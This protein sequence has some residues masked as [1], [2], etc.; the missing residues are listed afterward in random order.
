MK[1]SIR[2]IWLLLALLC[3]ASAQQPAQ[4]FAWDVK[5]APD[6]TARSNLTVENFCKKKHSFRITLENITFMRFRETEVTVAGRKTYDVP[7]VFDTARMIPGVNLGKVI[8]TCLTC[9]S[10]ATCTQDREVLAVRLEVT[11]SPGQLVTATAQPVTPPR[12]TDGPTEKPPC[13]QDLCEEARGRAW[14][15]EDGATAAEMLAEE[16]R[17]QADT[18]EQ[19]A[20]AAEDTGRQAATSVKDGGPGIVD[21][22]RKRSYTGNAFEALGLATRQ[23]FADLRDR[24]ITTA[25]AQQKTEQLVGL[26][27]LDSVQSV[28]S[29]NQAQ[30]RYTANQAAENAKQARAAANGAQETA[31][32]AQTAAKKSRED[33][34]QAR[35]KFEDCVGKVA[36]GCQGL[37]R[38]QQTATT[39]PQERLETINILFNTSTSLNT[40]T[41]TNPCEQLKI[42]CDKLRFEVANLE[43]QLTQAQAVLE[44]ARKRANNLEAEAQKAEESARRAAEADASLM[45]AAGAFT[46]KAISRRVAPQCARFGR[47]TA[48]AKSPPSRRN[49]WPRS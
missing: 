45:K 41:P 12:T 8:V 6:T 33:A 34:Q 5:L 36:A 20:R 27:G 11:G 35:N 39:Q 23:V 7:V 1:S 18:F 9:G 13:S 2:S 17:A 14:H 10:E 44:A 47:I 19:A 3:T 15:Q 26:D 40:S 21:E 38:D 24:K 48:Q 42:D 49:K 43:S 30:L 28:E 16:V 25:Q 22:E 4:Q 32:D 31:R 46:P 37:V 29:R